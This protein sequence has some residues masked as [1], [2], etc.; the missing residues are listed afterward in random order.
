MVTP[1]LMSVALMARG[2]FNSEKVV[3]G[4]MRA[5]YF[6][7]RRLVAKP[8]QDG[9]QRPKSAN[10]VVWPIS[11]IFSSET[12]EQKPA[13]ISAPT[14]VPAKRAQHADV[15]DTA[16]KTSGQRQANF[17][18]HGAFAIA[19]M[20]KLAKFILREAQP[21]QSFAYL[22]IQHEILF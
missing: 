16:R 6:S 15:R 9:V 5:R 11:C 14:L 21:F 3:A 13:P 7:M 10:V 18:A 17:R 20:G 22:T 12:P 2:I 19:A 1:A 8:S 4:V